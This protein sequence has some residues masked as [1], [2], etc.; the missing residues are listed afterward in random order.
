VLC[1]RPGG[2]GEELS[3][4]QERTDSAVDLFRLCGGESPRDVP[5]SLAHHRRIEQWFEITLLEFAPEVVHFQHLID[6]SPRLIQMAQRYGCATVLSLHD[7]YFACPR[8]ILQQVGGRVCDGPAGGRECVRA[9]FA[10]DA[11]H[12]QTAAALANRAMYFRRLL[13]LPDYLLCPSQ[14]VANFFRRWGG[15]EVA[16]RVRVV[17]NG[18]WV[19]DGLGHDAP[20]TRP[21]PRQ[22]GG[23]NIGFLGSITPHK[24]VHVLLEA[25]RLAVADGTELPIHI[26]LHG[27]SDPRYAAQ[28]RAQ[29]EG[30]PGLDVTLH[31]T[32]EPAR[33][34]D[35]LRDT[36]CVVAPSQWPEIFLLVTREAMA[37]GVPVAVTRLGALPE[38]VKEGENGFFFDH[39]HPEQLA[40]IL[41][42]LSADE[43]LLRHLRR[44]AR[45]AKPLSVG[46]HARIVRGIYKEA[47]RGLATR[48]Q[49]GTQALHVELELLFD[50]LLDGG[51]DPY[52]TFRDR[53]HLTSGVTEAAEVMA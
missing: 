19:T 1:R 13:A 28:I 40:Q 4:L 36:D 26:N 49:T 2:E 20:D 41:R 21:T 5:L 24:G 33:V 31:G 23:L 16:E 42:R 18:I 50:A 14:H 35:L 47:L 48:A 51:A 9:C 29:A 38:A 27:P 46:D 39:D 30:T 11:H 3:L 53:N 15:P 34:P 45:A 52:D 12:R 44:G 25:A 43:A 10:C 7:F 32:Y 17:P 6:L 22:R 37:C 8:I